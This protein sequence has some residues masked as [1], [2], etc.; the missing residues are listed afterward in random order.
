MDQRGQVEPMM[1]RWIGMLAALGIAFGAFPADALT[2]DFEEFSRGAIVGESHGVLITTENFN[3]APGHPDLGIAFDTT[4]TGTA[5]PDLQQGAG[6]AGG[7]LAADT[8]LHHILVVQENDFLCE[9]D[10]ICDDPDDERRRPAGSFTLD[11]SQLGTFQTFAFDLVDVERAETANG[12]VEFLLEGVQ[13]DSVT[14][15]EFLGLTYGNRTAN[16]VDL[17]LV[18]EFDEVV[19]T[20]GGSGGVDNIVT[21]VPEP[22]T[23][24]LFGLGLAGL[25]VAGRRR[26][27]RVAKKSASPA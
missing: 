17:G 3:D 11:F 25:I 16:H 10:S 15:D 19:I 9:I 24:S 13:V 6:W 1:R 18:G 22:S 4:E 5:D 2:I 21:F 23:L 26:P 20:M 12:S 27:P 7:N 14:F 8:V